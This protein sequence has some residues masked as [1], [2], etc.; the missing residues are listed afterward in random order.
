MLKRLSIP[1]L[2]AVLALATPAV[3]NETII[4]LSLDRATVIKAP[5]N[6]AMVVIGNPGVADVSVQKNGVIVLTGKSFGET[7][8]IALS[9]KG[10]MISES[11]LRVR[12]S[13]RTS[14]VVVFRA[15]EP[16]TF[17]CTPDCQPTV[18]L[19]D[20][21]KFFGRAGSQSVTRNGFAQSTPAAPK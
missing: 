1:A 15:G 21:E 7:N 9:D 11:W 14:N 12:P 18:S 19:G 8:M 4:S 3:A 17:S 6:T 2:A 5:A 20:S 10:E 16:E 13:Q